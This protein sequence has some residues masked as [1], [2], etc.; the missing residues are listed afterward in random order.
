FILDNLIAAKK[1]KPMLVVMPAGHTGPFSFVMRTE[2]SQGSGPVGN[3]RFED[4]FVKDVLPYVEKH[5]RVTPDRPN[6]ALAGLSMGGA[7]TLNVAF[8]RPKDFAYVGVFSSGV[9]FSKAADWEKDHKEGLGDAKEGLK[10]LW[11]AT[12]SEDFLLARTKESVELF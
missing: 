12:G 1:A 5:Y 3:A 6:R 7:Q 2:R 11:F 4:D 8:S 9:V 10:L